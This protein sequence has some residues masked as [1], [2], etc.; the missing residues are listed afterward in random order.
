[1]VE[2]PT[3]TTGPASLVR[4][5]RRHPLLVALVA[6][7]AVAAAVLWIASRATSYEATAEILVTPAPDDSGPDRGLPLLRTSGDRTRVVQ[8]AASLIDSAGAAQRT[9][10]ALGG[11]WTRQ[12]VDDAVTVAPLGQTDVVAVT[13]EADSSDLAVQIAN[14]FARSA[15]DARAQVLRPRISALR[16]QLQEELRAQQDPD[17]QAALDIQERLSELNAIQAAGD[18]TLSLT[19]RAVAPASSVGTTPWLVLAAALIA[20]LLVG[21]GAAMVADL[22]GAQTVADAAHAAAITDAPVL[23]Q[24]R[25]PHA[26][27][28]P[29]PAVT[30]AARTL[31]LM[32]MG[33]GRSPAI[34]FVS[35]LAG[36]EA[37]ACTLGFAAGL[38]RAGRRVL[39][40]DVDQGGAV[41]PAAETE[42]YDC[43]LVHGG[44][45][46][47][48]GAAAPA[49][50][51]ADAVVL[52][53]RSRHTTVDDMDLALRLLDRAGGRTDAVVLVTG[54]RRLDRR[55][56]VEVA[57]PDVEVMRPARPETVAEQDAAPAPVAAG[58]EDVVAGRRP[59][60]KRVSRRH[61]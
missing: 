42:R 59:R 38:E 4:S 40:V 2:P 34:V 35:P 41:P 39:V 49:A 1:M 32:I 26:G 55:Q 17:S 44:S 53:V 30:R 43:V 11:D 60:D 37:A 47:E 27:R 10:D 7:A 6:I 18:P 22:I 14:T 3:Y 20:G 61:A 46:I 28:A 31:E 19:R 9:A 33:E 8:T 23:A 13:A 21:T 45:I 24:I 51:A 25:L 16:I 50:A 58:E 56:V 12:R 52:V 29:P 54:P 48:S 5:V 36:D 15:L 57:D